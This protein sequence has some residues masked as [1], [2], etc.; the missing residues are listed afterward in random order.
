MRQWQR[1]VEE[2]TVMNRREAIA[3]EVDLALE[4]WSQRWMIEGN[5]VVCRLCLRRQRLICAHDVFNHRRCA[6]GCL[7]KKDYPWQT[8]AHILRPFAE[9]Q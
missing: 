8:L 7:L 6:W 4:E 5:D 3:V 1:P 2:V 9:E